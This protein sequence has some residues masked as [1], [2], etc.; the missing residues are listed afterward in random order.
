MID[1]CNGTRVQLDCIK[2]VIKGLSIR[3]Q[4]QVSKMEEMPFDLCIWTENS[5]SLSLSPSAKANIGNHLGHLGFSCRK[6][7]CRRP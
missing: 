3:T 5:I 4:K 6:S 1:E 2:R 7:Y